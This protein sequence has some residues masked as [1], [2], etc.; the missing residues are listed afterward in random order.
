MGWKTFWQRTPQP[1]PMLELLIQQQIE[2]QK[3]LLALLKRRDEQIDRVLA[4]EFDRPQISAE[5]IPEDRHVIPAGILS[6]VL[7]APTDEEFFAMAKALNN[8]NP[9]PD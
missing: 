4:S 1:Q 9:K 8:P 7:E 6:D 5:S 3:E 2:T